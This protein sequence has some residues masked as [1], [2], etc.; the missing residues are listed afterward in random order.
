MHSWKSGAARVLNTLLAVCRA[1]FIK[2]MHTIIHKRHA[3]THT[4]TH[5]RQSDSY[6]QTHIHTKDTQTHIHTKDM[7]THIHTKDTQTHLSKHH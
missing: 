1:H 2:L 5:N 4:Q 6:T 3:D 7:L